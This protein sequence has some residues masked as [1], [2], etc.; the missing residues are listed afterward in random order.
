MSLPTP[1]AG[2]SLS[3]GSSFS[4][5][6]RALSRLAGEAEI[7]SSLINYKAD[8][9]ETGQAGLDRVARRGMFGVAEIS[10][11]EAQLAQLVP[12]ATSRLQAIGDAH[13][14]GTVAIVMDFAKSL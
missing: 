5:T 3:T 12:L 13:A 7:G 9:A 4:R 6:G 2:R 11:T 8:L 14:L 1:Y 10:Q